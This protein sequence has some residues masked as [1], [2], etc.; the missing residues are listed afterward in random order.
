VELYGGDSSNIFAIGQSAGGAHLA[1]AL[2]SGLLQAEKVQI[3]GAILQSVPFW[4]DLTQERRRKNMLLYHETDEDEKVLQLTSLACFE[5]A[6]GDQLMK[7]S[8]LVMIGEFDPHEIVEGNVRFVQAF[9]KRMGHLPVLEVME[10]HNHISY[11][12]G[13]GAAGDEIGPRI[14]QWVKNHARDTQGQSM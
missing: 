2:F 11:A 3:S 5:A 14:L 7:Q 10:G 1:T 8:L 12:L 9:R 4:Y 13:I 6:D